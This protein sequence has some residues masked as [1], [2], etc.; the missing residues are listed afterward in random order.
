MTFRIEIARR[1]AREIE[2]QY[3]WLARRSQAAA[4]KLRDSLLDAI[5]SLEEDPERC[6]EAPEAKWYGPGLR[7]LLHGKRRIMYRILFEIRGDVVVVLRVRHSAQD[8]LSP[9]DL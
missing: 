2:N 1:A 5:S 3:H 6:P 8:L 7:Q 9:E 4:G